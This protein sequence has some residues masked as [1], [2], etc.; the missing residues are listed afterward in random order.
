MTIPTNTNTFM[1]HA[2]RAID[3]TVRV[4]LSVAGGAAVGIP[5]GVATY[6]ATVIMGIG[7][8][9]SAGGASLSGPA[10][11]GGVV[12]YNLVGTFLFPAAVAGGLYVGISQGVSAGRAI[13]NA[14]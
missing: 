9:L 6:F 1:H 10:T 13:Y 11:V 7:L 3:T 14:L 8:Q 4:S 2:V 12:A 5:S